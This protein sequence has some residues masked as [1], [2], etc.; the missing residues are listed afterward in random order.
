MTG[1]DRRSV[2][3]LLFEC[4]LTSRRLLLDPDALDT[5]AMLRVWP[6]L[7]QAGHEFL[8]ALPGP[9]SRRVPGLAG[10]QTPP[11]PV[12]ERLHLMATALNDNLRP[13][14]W[15]GAGP[16]DETVL[17]MTSNL[18]RAHDLLERGLRTTVPPS[19]AVQADAA[20]ARTRVL[21]VLY[22][23]AHVISLAAGADARALQA[24]SRATQRRSAVY[25]L[26]ALKLV[27]ARLDTF[28][29]V[30]G[31]EVYRSFPGALVGE[32]REEAAPDRLRRALATWEVE[33]HRALVSAPSLG[34]IAELTGVQSATIALSHVL[35]GASADAGVID[36]RAFRTGMAPRLAAAA[37]AW[38]DLHAI[39]RD[40]TATGPREVS[41]EL[42][43]A[44]SELVQALADLALDGTK[45][46][47]GATVTDRIHI[48]DVPKTLVRALATHQDASQAVLDAALDPRARVSARAAQRV[49]TN[50]ASKSPESVSPREPWLSPGDIANGRQVKL[51]TPIRGALLQHIAVVEKASALMATAAAD[52][53]RAAYP[54]RT[55]ARTMGE[56]A[57]GRPVER[58]KDVPSRGA[59]RLAR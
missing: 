9:S 3:E 23:T 54:G 56:I 53:T 45:V 26:S 14:P 7:V 25:K 16:A 35:L 6:E 13:R 22:V 42:R 29:Q 21:H 8:A 44:G 34:N 28:E 37:S 46:A 51:P 52:L 55:D 2:G 36:A 47:S 27:A 48:S 24:S 20:A 30:V 43:V 59:P 11:D 49:I 38:G 18:V 4:D 58:L 19:A 40:L 1:P 32:R 39:A 15:P 57:Q 17:A 12:A 5:A 10:I 31:A 41:R 50:R 33:A